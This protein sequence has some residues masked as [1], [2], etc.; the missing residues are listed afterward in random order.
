LGETLG[1]KGA[2]M[3]ERR[4]RSTLPIRDL[5]GVHGIDKLLRKGD[6]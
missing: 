2:Q 4:A 1:K 5:L 6:G 3:K